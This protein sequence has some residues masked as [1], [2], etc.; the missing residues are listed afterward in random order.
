MG[1][2]EK[3]TD[4]LALHL[5]FMCQQVSCGYA[6]GDGSVFEKNI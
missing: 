5:D 1:M 2:L 6:Q 4:S 3:T